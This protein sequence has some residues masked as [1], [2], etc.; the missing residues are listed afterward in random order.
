MLAGVLRA[1]AGEVEQVEEDL[2]VLLERLLLAR[3]RVYADGTC[4]PIAEPIRVAGELP[5][6]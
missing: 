6:D 1:G 3:Q 4:A 2:R 5:A